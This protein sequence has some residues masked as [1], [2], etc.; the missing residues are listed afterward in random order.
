MNKYLKEFNKSDSQDRWK[1][2]NKYGFAVPN[3]NALQAIVRNCNFKILELGSGAGY[4]AHLLA[5]LGV[6][7]I[8]IDDLSW[9]TH[10]FWRFEKI[11]VEPIVGSTE[12]IDNYPQHTLMLIWPNHGSH[13]AAN[14][15][16]CY[17]GNKVIYV[18]ERNGGCTANYSFFER[19]GKYWTLIEEVDLDQ[20]EGIHDNLYIYER[21]I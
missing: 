6:N 14:C 1:L 20:W 18:G 19:L 21:K 16:E 17:Q 12:Q 5:Y 8:C 10:H 4:W 9:K 3:D 13:F 15:L 2:V 11:Y 7:V